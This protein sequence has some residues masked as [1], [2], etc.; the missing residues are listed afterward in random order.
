MSKDK[1]VVNYERIERFIQAECEWPNG[2][3][4]EI[5]SQMLEIK[6]QYADWGNLNISY[7]W[8]GYEDCEYYVSGTRLENDDE[9][10]CRIE[11]EE[12]KLSF[13]EE[14]ESERI[15]K[16]ILENQIQMQADL[17]EL[18]RLKAKYGEK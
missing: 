2:T 7:E 16:E 12:D 11:Q 14:K 8:S 5:I 18:A 15:A 17:K 10:N 6:K 1:P 3:P 9:Y 4:D 13:W